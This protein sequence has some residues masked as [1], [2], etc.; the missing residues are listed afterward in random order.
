MADIV[1]F[2]AMAAGDVAAVHALSAEMRWPHRPEDLRLFESIGAGYVG[3]D[4]GGAV[5]AA[6]LWWPYGEGLATIGMVIVTARLQGRGIGRRLMGRLVAAA[7]DRT[8]RLT[9]TQAGRPLYETLGFRVSGTVTQHQ[10]RASAAAVRPALAVRAAEPRDW[11]AIVALDAE[12]TGGDRARLYAGLLVEGTAAVLERDGAIRGVSVCRSFGRG[13]VIGPIVCRDDAD[14]VAL[15]S[16]HLRAHDGA[17]LRVDTTVTEGPFAELLAGSGL[18]NVDRS[19]QM[20]RGP[21]EAPG[22]AR[23]FGLASQALG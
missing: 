8:I 15:A 18:A 14:A 6:G 4:A 2:R 23:T 21:L 20:T 5:V 11:P 9:A 3:T 12:A 13:H 10:G 7:G 19:V 17:F 1:Q 16:P 22:P